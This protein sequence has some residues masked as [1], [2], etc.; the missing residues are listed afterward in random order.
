M[1]KSTAASS[2]HARCWRRPRAWDDTSHSMRSQLTSRAPRARTTHARSQSQQPG[3]R[4]AL[5]RR[6]SER[7]AIGDA[8]TI[9]AAGDEDEDKKPGENDAAVVRVALSRP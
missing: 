9:E 6:A 2:A 7:R 1:Q 8:S 3:P 4:I 5:C